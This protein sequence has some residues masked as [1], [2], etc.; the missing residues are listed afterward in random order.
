MG[1]SNRIKRAK[2]N[3]RVMSLNNYSKVKNLKISSTITINAT[4][5]NGNTSSVV[6]M[7]LNCADEYTVT[8][9]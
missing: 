8:Y 1:K 7:V 5:K 3:E 2:D 9:P 4:V 6:K